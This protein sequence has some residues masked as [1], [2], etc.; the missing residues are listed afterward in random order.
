ME[1]KR[2]FA[3]IYSKAY[4]RGE[5]ICL[6]T[7][8]GIIIGEVVNIDKDYKELAEKSTYKKELKDEKELKNTDIEL[9]ADIKEFGSSIGVLANFHESLYNSIVDD[10]NDAKNLTDQ[11]IQHS[12]GDYIILKD[13]TLTTP[14]I[15]T[16]FSELLVFTDEIIGISIYIEQN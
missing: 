16:N 15:T 1:F 6:I 13:A 7:S 3:D 4:C 5:K 14:N 12:E 2:F 8:A 9:A 10:L 11:P